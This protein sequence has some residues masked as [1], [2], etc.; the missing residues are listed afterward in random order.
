MELSFRLAWAVYVRGALRVLSLACRP[1]WWWISSFRLPYLRPIF[2][3]QIHP[4]K[5]SPDRRVLVGFTA[6]GSKNYAKNVIY[7]DYLYPCF[8]GESAPKHPRKV[9]AE[10]ANCYIVLRKSLLV[11]KIKRLAGVAQLVEHDVANVVVVGSNPITRS[12][13]STAIHTLA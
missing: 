10:S 3:P 6:C 12:L 8:V 4:S 5:P 11:N 2:L 13:R 7:T 1:P 9:P